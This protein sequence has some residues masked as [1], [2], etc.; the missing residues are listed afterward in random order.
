MADCVLG[1]ATNRVIITDQC[2]G[3]TICA[4]DGE[5][6]D[7]EY[8]RT[9]DDTSEAKFTVYLTGGPSGAA[10]CKCIGGVRSKIHAVTIYRQDDLVWGPG[11]ITNIVERHGSITIT[12]R[13][14][15][16]WLDARVIHHDL[17]FV[18]VPAR[19]IALA[20]IQDAMAPDDPCGIAE[21]VIQVGGPGP[22]IDKSYAAGRVYAGDALRELARTSI[23]YTASGLAIVLGDVLSFGPF[24]V[25]GDE[26]FQTEI[27]VEERGIEAATKWYANGDTVQGVAGGL[28]PY[29]GLIE[30]ITDESDIIAQAEADSASAGRLESSNP[31]P[32]YINIPDGA[33]LSPKAPVCFEKLIPGSLYDVDLRNRCRPVNQRFRLTALKVTESGSNSENVGV[34]LSPEGTSGANA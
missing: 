13:D 9:M 14:V 2:G 6:G 16:E 5:I 17:N 3:Q 15:T 27:E 1:C 26:D 10:C 28:D 29:Y 33:G 19:D 31:A 24:G 23:D 18:G 8:G 7:V 25:L 32:L 21:K 20:I 22:L 12:A 34:T 4:F 11:R 30:Q